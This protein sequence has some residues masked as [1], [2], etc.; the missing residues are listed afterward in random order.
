MSE[1]GHERR[2]AAPDAT[3]VAVCGHCEA[4]LTVTGPPAGKGSSALFSVGCVRCQGR[5]LLPVAFR[6][7]TA[8]SLA[9][10][11]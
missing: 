4:R 8:I 10:P 7:V 6:R 11:S 5:V 1:S 9:E 3:Q 2:S